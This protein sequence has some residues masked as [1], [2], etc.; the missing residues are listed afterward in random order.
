MTQFSGTMVA[1]TRL[2]IEAEHLR[3][4]R[5]NFAERTWRDVRFPR[6]WS[7]APAVLVESFEEGELVSKYTIQRTL[8]VGGGQELDRRTAHF[9]V[10]RGEDIYLKML[11][12]DNL[13]HADL[14][15]GNILGARS[16]RPGAPTS[17][18]HARPRRARARE[19]R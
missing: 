12:A 4:F 6:V 19:W 14:H 7:G 9:V 5:W 2:D 17:E 16:A 10:S 15:P 3:R 18:C 13:M 8:G 1:Q 11:L